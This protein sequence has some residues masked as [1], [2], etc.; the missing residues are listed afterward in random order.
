[1][2]VGLIALIGLK[3]LC[4]FSLNAIPL[5]KEVLIMILKFLVLI[6]ILIWILLLIHTCS[7]KHCIFKL[8]FKLIKIE[9]DPK[10]IPQTTTEKD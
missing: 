5:R 7:K 4:F 1:M 3:H 10:D 9:V 2:L 6:I 8:D